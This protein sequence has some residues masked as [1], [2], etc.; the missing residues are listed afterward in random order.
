MTTMDALFK[1][2]GQG[3]VMRTAASQDE[4]ERVAAFNGLIHG[5]ELAVTMRRLLRG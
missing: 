3:L 5:P 2:L 1:D 4:V